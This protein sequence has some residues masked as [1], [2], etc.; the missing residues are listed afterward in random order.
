MP[1]LRSFEAI[2]THASEGTTAAEN[3]V[4]SEL[5][6]NKVK[7]AKLTFM[8]VMREN[9]GCGRFTTYFFTIYIMNYGKILIKYVYSI[10][11]VLT[12]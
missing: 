1:S 6:V 9:G 11:V 5:N 3:A 10:G 8:S 7:E 2:G 12:L 4:L